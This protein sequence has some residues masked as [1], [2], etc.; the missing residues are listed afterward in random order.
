MGGSSRDRHRS[1]SSSPLRR[2]C[3]NWQVRS[4][5]G[6]CLAP[7]SFQIAPRSHALGFF[8]R[9]T[10]D[11]N[12]VEITK[13]CLLAKSENQTRERMSPGD[14]GVTGMNNLGII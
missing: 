12:E 2:D 11:E 6:V 7:E 13:S 9:P 8:W 10:S 4:E 14:R 1:G 5:I 3:K